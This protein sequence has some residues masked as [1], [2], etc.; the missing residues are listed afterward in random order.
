MFSIVVVVPHP[1]DETAFCAGLI[2]RALRKS[3]PVKVIY[4]TSGAHGRTLGLVPQSG[5]AVERKKEAKLATG[6]LGVED[7]SF[8]GYPDFDPR[9]QKKFAWPG[10]RSKLHA[11]AGELS[12]RS[13]IVSF[14]PNGINGHPDHVLCSKLAAGLAAASGAGL[15][16]ATTSAAE[17]PYQDVPSYMK[18]R[19]RQ[20]LHLAPTHAVKLTRREVTRKLL[21]LSQ[22]R[23]QALS[24][25]DYIKYAEGS[26]FEEN[27]ALARNPRAHAEKL[28]GEIL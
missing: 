24:M 11:C 25:L 23:T 9:R 16:Y 19:Q 15:L 7:V 18:A 6:V 2:L 20:K 12:S 10:V 5:L 13:V 28:L 27:F 26:L 17:T 22:Y 14:P 3:L 1:D 4:L 21:A 8:L